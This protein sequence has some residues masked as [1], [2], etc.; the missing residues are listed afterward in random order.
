MHI[1]IFSEVYGSVLTGVLEMKQAA[2]YQD[3]TTI[4]CILRGNDK[5][6]SDMEMPKKSSTFSV[7]DWN[8]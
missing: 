2:Q 7:A 8:D 3:E 5:M 4:K 1:I 6:K